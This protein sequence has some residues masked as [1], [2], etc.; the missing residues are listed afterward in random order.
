[1]QISDKFSLSAVTAL[2]ALTTLSGCSE[3]Q[4]KAA[5]P[6]APPPAAVSVVTVNMEPV[7]GY[8]EFAARTA[9]SET[10]SL[11]ARIE[12][13]LESSNFN[14]GSMVEKGQQLFSIDPAPFKAALSQANA[15]LISAKADATRTLSD[16]TRGRELEPKGYI[17]KAD[18][19]K[20]VSNEAMA[21]AKVAASEAQKKAAE[22]NLSYTTIYAPF[23]GLI[24]KETY[25]V[26]SLVGPSS[27]PLAEL[28]NIN[29]IYVN[30]QVNEKTLLQHNKAGMSL[31]QASHDYS[32]TLKLPTG[33]IYGQEGTLN[34]ANVKVDATTGTVDIRAAFPNPSQTLLP[35]MYVTIRME[36]NEKVDMPLIPQFAVQENQQGRFVLVVTADNTVESRVVQLGRRIGPMWVVESGLKAGEKIIVSGLQKVRPNATVSPQLMTVN[37]ETGVLTPAEKSGAH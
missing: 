12:G 3:E 28:I 15:E 24:G 18:M 10:V 21:R 37:L 2:I 7:G 30:F 17:S 6:M 5:T 8:Q 9:A 11:R 1:M 13:Y 14:E 27:D 23:S 31:E 4:G 16:L 34:F 25:S 33:H 22:I 26:G 29:P 19:D 20:L 32:I 36:S 35:G